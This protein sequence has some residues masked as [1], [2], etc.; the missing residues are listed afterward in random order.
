MEEETETEKVDE[1]EK[2]KQ[3]L[4]LFTQ[5]FFKSLKNKTPFAGTGLTLWLYLL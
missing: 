4:H 1:Y 2:G 5:L 3:A